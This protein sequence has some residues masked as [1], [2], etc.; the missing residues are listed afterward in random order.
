MPYSPQYTPPTQAEMRA[1]L[2]RT[3]RDPT[4]AVF[5][6]D[7]VNDF[8]NEGLMN[9]SGY[10]PVEASETFAFE[11]VTPGDTQVFKLTVLSHVWQ[12]SA[13]NPNDVT[14]V[15][16]DMTL[17]YK[18]DS[19]G[20]YSP[21]P[22]GWEVYAGWLALSRWTINNLAAWQS[23]VGG[24]LS[25]F[26]AGYRD[27]FM[28]VADDEILD[29]EDATD[30]LCLTREARALGFQALSNDR[31]LYQQWLAATNNTDVSPTQLSGML[32]GAISDVEK[33][34]KRSAVLRRTPISGF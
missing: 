14:S 21:F 2:Y 27:R 34:R 23:S 32:N 4:G 13:S 17:P 24:P 1:I 22:V 9:M 6:G 26:V 29:L 12:V 31:A 33:Q 25:L 7:T 20:V 11:P 5:G 3:L 30:Q 8:I 16:Q 15:A 28:P 18:G 10:R 19:G